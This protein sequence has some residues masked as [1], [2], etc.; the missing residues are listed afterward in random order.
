MQ[1]LGHILRL[2]CVFS[3]VM[4]RIFV[5]LLLLA[6]VQY[7]NG[8]YVGGPEKDPQRM[9]ATDGTSSDPTRGDIQLRRRTRS[10]P[11]SSLVFLGSLWDEC[12]CCLFTRKL[13]YCCIERFNQSNGR[14]R[15]YYSIPPAMTKLTLPLAR[16]FER[17]PIQA[18]KLG[19]LYPSM[20]PPAQGDEKEWNR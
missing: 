6:L 10:F 18:F 13:K 12:Q 16:P 19:T 4:I 20:K 9:N 15:V 1:I 2:H 3:A 17:A 14:N 8:L 7:N 11:P 5:F